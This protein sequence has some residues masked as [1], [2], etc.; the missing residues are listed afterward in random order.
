MSFDDNIVSVSVVVLVFVVYS[1]TRRADHKYG[2]PDDDVRENIINYDDE[3]GGEDDMNAYDI[4]PLRIPIDANG[5][6]LNAK[7]GPE[8]PI[9]DPRQRRCKYIHA[10]LDRRSHPRFV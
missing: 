3:G 5:T 6:P 2:D 8:K 10:Q 4:T 9:K 7:P 1:R